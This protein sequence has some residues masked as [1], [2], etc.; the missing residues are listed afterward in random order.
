MAAT[1]VQA[2][3]WGRGGSQHDAREA[4]GGG[5]EGGAARS[6]IAVTSLR[7]GA[8]ARARD[9][10]GGVRIGCL[11]PGFSSIAGGGEWHEGVARA[12]RLHWMRARVA[13]T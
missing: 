3:E 5:E 12:M 7:A 8:G 10:H 4:S 1:Q 13:G 6:G 2:T 9:A 11:Q